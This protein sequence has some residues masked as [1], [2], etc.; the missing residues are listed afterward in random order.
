MFVFVYDFEDK[1]E[2]YNKK[3]DL[4]PF[5]DSFS[6]PQLN[7]RANFCENDIFY[8]RKG[9]T[10]RVKT[11]LK[12]GLCTTDIEFVVEGEMNFKGTHVKDYVNT[13]NY[14]DVRSIDTEQ[15]FFFFP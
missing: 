12:K 14:G 4:L 13:E 7:D 8:K 15:K 5:L 6:L 2:I 1:L 9:V 11:Q 3:V 10:I